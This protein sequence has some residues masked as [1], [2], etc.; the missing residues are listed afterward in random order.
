MSFDVSSPSYAIL[1]GSV[2]H[3]LA[4]HLELGKVQYDAGCRDLMESL[5]HEAFLQRGV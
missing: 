1:F 4:I 5:A 3:A 2:Y